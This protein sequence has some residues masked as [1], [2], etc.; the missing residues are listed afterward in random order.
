[1]P[2]LGLALSFLARHPLHNQANGMK[3]ISEQR[4]SPIMSE[5]KIPLAFVT[6]NPDVLVVY[7][8]RLP[9]CGKRQSV[10]LCYTGRSAGSL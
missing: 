5:R 2:A 8:R 9:H 7:S 6:H 4:A 10:K 3:T 1:M